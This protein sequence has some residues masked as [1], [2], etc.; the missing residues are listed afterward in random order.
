METNLPKNWRCDLE[1]ID[2]DRIAEIINASLEGSDAEFRVSEMEEIED[3]NGKVN[4]FRAIYDDGGE[5]EL[6]FE[7][8]KR[9]ASY[10]NT[11][12]KEIEA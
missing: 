8:I 12:L 6:T 2:L 4:G 5:Y 9:E 11:L 1:M 10:W 3:S 7:G